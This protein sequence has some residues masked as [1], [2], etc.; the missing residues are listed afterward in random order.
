MLV[1]TDKVICYYGS[2]AHYRS[3]NGKVSASDLNPKLCTH[4]IYS[5]VGITESGG[6]SILDQWLDIDLG[7]IKNTVALKNINPKLK[8]LAAIGGWNQGGY[9]FSLVAENPTLRAQ[10]VK[11]V[12]SFVQQHKL[13]GFDIDWEYPAGNGGRPQ[14]K[15]TVVVMRISIIMVALF[16][17]NHDLFVIVA[18]LCVAAQRIA[19]CLR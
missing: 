3:G 13:D 1:F 2:W 6:V 7:G 5:F 17:Q 9:K 4:I 15:V 14:D 10:F 8:V 19:C 11:N 18:K 16:L 12:V